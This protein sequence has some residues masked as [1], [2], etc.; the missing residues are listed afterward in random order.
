M[1]QHL[2]LGREADAN[3]TIISSTGQEDDSF[4]WPRGWDAAADQSLRGTN[5]AGYERMKT[6]LKLTVNQL[7]Q[8]YFHQMLMVT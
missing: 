1:Q 5:N 6:D 2:S 3:L 7:K 4:F 8:L